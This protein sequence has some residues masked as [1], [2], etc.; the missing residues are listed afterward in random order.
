MVKKSL[1]TREA[2]TTTTDAVISRRPVVGRITALEASRFLPA[3]PAF[4]HTFVLLT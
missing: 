3:L 1:K 4:T 2:A